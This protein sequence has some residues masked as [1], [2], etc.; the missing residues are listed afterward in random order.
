VDVVLVHGAWQ[1]AWCW[2][3]VAPLL[4]QEGHRVHTPTLTG[5]GERASELTREVTLDTHLADVSALVGRLDG[6]QVL[7]VGHSYSGMVIS[8]VADRLADRLAGLFYLDAFYPHDG[9]SALGLM[10]PPF[11]EAFRRSA[12]ADGDGWRLPANDGLLDVWGLHD[13]EDREWVRQRLTDW[14][15]RCFQSPVRLPAGAR[16]RLPRTFLRGAAEGYPARVAFGAQAQRADADGCR[17]VELPTGHDMMIEAPRA[18]ADV[19]SSVA[20]QS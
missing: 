10:P 2:D 12:E 9:D 14:S 15:L 17:V 16:A 3:R 1:G 18:V 7:L 19:L 4:Q 8:G 6:G 5:S 11:Q 13:P 20:S